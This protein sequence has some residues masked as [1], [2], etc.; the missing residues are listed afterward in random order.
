MF[1]ILVFILDPYCKIVVP[2]TIPYLCFQA[3]MLHIVVPIYCSVKCRRDLVPLCFLAAVKKLW[4][5]WWI[6]LQEISKH[7]PFQYNP[8]DHTMGGGWIFG[9]TGMGKDPDVWSANIWS[10]PNIQIIPIRTKGSVITLL[11]M[12]CKVDSIL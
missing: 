6:T 9:R 3:G 10:W 8:S 5:L 7:I 1:V 4:V 2:H 11:W 12:T